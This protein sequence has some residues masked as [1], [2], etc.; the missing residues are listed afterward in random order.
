MQEK[1]ET[2]DQCD[3][4]QVRPGLDP[5]IP[6][7]K[8][9]AHKQISSLTQELKD[10]T[11]ALEKITKIMVDNFKDQDPIFGT[12]R[13]AWLRAYAFAKDVLAKYTKEKDEKI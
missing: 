9:W 2:K 11:E 13:A 1:I 3:C 12:Y 4:R 7:E 5:T 10:K 8:C 6:I